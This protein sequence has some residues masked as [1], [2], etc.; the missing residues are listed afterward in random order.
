MCRGVAKVFFGIQRK[1]GTPCRQC[2]MVEAKNH[3]FCQGVE[4]EE[5]EEGGSLTQEMGLDEQA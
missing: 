3:V 5:G 2:V 1:N 4:N